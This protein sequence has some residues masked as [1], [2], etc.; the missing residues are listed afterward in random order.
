[1]GQVPQLGI[2]GDGR[3]A[4]HFGHYFNLLGIPV[5]TWSR[6]TP[7]PSP[8]DALGRCHAV[9]LLISDDAIVPFVQSWPTL[10]KSRLVHCS[11]VLATPLAEAAH[12]LMTFGPDLYDLATYRAIPFILDEGRT[13]L[14]ELLPGLPNP[15]FTIPAAARPYYHALCVMAGNF[16]TLLW[17]KLFDEF[18]ARFGI[19]ASAAHP[20]A[21]RVAANL[22]A[23]RG[24][25]LTGP[26]SRHDVRTIAANLEALEGDPFHDVYLAFVRAH[27]HRP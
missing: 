25:A 4:R 10:R 3:V 22:L 24:R 18:E 11:G 2:V 14:A 9:L 26:L 19:P 21:A 1:V 12:P 23:D 6:R 7:A 27:E 5:R 17:Q 15:W 20:Y 13:P 16:S 8:P